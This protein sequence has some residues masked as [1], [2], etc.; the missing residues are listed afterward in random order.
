MSSRDFHRID[1]VYHSMYR[2]KF[3]R[4]EPFNNE[5]SESAGEDTEYAAK[6]KEHTP[7]AAKAIMHK[8]KLEYGD[9]FN[10]EKAKAAV[11]HALGSA[12]EEDCEGWNQDYSHT[13]DQK[14][15]MIRYIDSEAAEEELGV[16]PKDAAEYDKARQ[17]ISYD[18]YPFW[19]AYHAVKEG[20]W[21]E[22]DFHQWCQTVWNAGAEESR[23]NH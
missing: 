14:K 2:N 9:K 21:S 6:A 23:Y 20:A 15:D 22:E 3:H 13:L 18:K 10:P 11:K 4:E 12:T 8:L 17:E 16:D 7:K 1:E 5:D 19:D